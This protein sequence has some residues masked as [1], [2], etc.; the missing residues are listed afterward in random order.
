V[1]VV[2]PAVVAPVIVGLNVPELIKVELVQF[3][4]LLVIKFPLVPAVDG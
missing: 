3:V 4:P 1:Y 2:V